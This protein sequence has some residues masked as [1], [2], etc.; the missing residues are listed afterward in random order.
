MKDCTAVLAPV[1]RATPRPQK[2]D[3]AMAIRYSTLLNTGNQQ[4]LLVHNEP[5]CNEKSGVFFVTLQV[6]RVFFFFFLTR[7]HLLF[8]AQL[9]WALLLSVGIEWL[10]AARTFRVVL[11]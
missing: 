2:N 4:C 8:V 1:A 7:C 3:D 10:F 9:L 6:F 11:T 5:N